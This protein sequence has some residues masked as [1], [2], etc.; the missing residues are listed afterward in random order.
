MSQSSTSSDSM[1]NGTVGMMSRQSF[2]GNLITQRLLANVEVSGALAHQLEFCCTA[3]GKELSYRLLGKSGQEVDVWK[4][5]SSW[6]TKTLDL[7]GLRGNRLEKL[8]YYIGIFG[9]TCFK[10]NHGKKRIYMELTEHSRAFELEGMFFK[11]VDFQSQIHFR[12]S[13][14]RLHQA[15]LIASLIF[16][17]PLTAEA[18]GA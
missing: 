12:C 10:T 16:N 1:V 13:K 4:F 9:G 18:S 5:K 8:E 7:N 17:P 2:W 14:R 6:A 15:I 11:H 3:F